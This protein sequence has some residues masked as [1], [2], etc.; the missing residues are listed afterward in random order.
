[1]KIDED[2]PTIINQYE[3]ESFKDN[4]RLMHKWYKE[5]LIPTDA[6]T[7]TEGYPLEGNTWFMREETQGPMDYGD[8]ILTNAAGKDIVSRPLTK[9]LKTTSQAQMANFVV[10]NVSKNKEKAVEV[11]S[12]LNSDPELLNGLVYGVEGKAWEK[13]ATRKSNC[14]MAI[15]QKC[16]WVLGILVTIKSF[17]LKNPLLTT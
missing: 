13:L 12:L 16:T 5:G 6:A 14:L 1:M 15:N 7:N 2:K 10:S 17:T 8:T 4:L 9:P 11:L 3:D